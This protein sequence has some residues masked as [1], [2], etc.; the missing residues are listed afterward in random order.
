V[1]HILGVKSYGMVVCGNI[2]G[3][4]EA[5]WGE[6]IHLGTYTEEERKKGYKKKSFIGAKY[7]FIDDMIEFGS[8]DSLAKRRPE[9]ILDVGCGIGGKHMN[10]Q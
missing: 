2:S 5:Y 6:H 8:L 7:D 10:S 4:L 9:K 1:D 3:I